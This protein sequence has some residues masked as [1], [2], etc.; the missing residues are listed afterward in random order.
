ME[1][2]FDTFTDAEV[3]DSLL[4]VVGTSSRGSPW[5]PPKTVF[6]REGGRVPVGEGRY[7]PGHQ[8]GHQCNLVVQALD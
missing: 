2:L 3:G 1:V 5:L 6:F 4:I 7:C 8:W